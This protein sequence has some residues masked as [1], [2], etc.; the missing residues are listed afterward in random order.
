VQLVSPCS[1]INIENNEIRVSR[2]IENQCNKVYEDLFLSKPEIRCLHQMNVFERVR[3]EIITVSLIIIAIIAS[4]GI[5][6]GDFAILETCKLNPRQ[7]D[8]TNTLDDLER[9]V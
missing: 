9:Q 8:L 4:A 5:G 2:A 6:L 1:L 7:K 3:R